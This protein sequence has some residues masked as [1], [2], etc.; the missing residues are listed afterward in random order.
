MFLNEAKKNEKLAGTSL[1]GVVW[2]QALLVLGIVLP[3]AAVVVLIV[4]PSLLD[5]AIGNIFSD[6]TNSL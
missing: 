4:L 3:I 5:P 2:L 6:I 1:P